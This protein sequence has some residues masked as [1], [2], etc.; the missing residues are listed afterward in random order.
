ME[1]GVIFR[2]VIEVLGK[3]Q[4]HVEKTLK[5]YVEKLRQ[6][7]EYGLMKVDFADLK[8]QEKEELWATFAEVEV[9]VD[10]VNK[11]LSFCFDYMPSIV[12][13]IQP[14]QLMFK[15]IEINQFINDL[16]ARLHHV[17]MVAKQLKMENDFLKRNTA[18]LMKNF[19]TILLQKKALTSAQL[20]AL[21][22]FNKD[23]LEDF[24]DNLIDAGKVDLKD[25]V[26]YLKK[27]ES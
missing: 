11:I 6:S 20:S 26:Y 27:E 8:K 22:G 7:S 23:E 19:L 14:K 3:P 13:I 5:G 25:D 18:S 1:S 15:D 17:D 16:Q 4:E 2:S 12:E 10:D 21:T 24:L 9:K